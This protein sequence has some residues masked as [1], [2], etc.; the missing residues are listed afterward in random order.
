MYN[1][2]SHGTAD[3]IRGEGRNRVVSPTNMHAMT[4]QEHRAFGRLSELLAIFSKLNCRATIIAVMN[5]RDCVYDNEASLSRNT[6][7]GTPLLSRFDTIFKLVDSSDA[8]RD[9]NVTKYLLNRAILQASSICY[10]DFFRKHFVPQ[11]L[12]L[13]S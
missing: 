1:S 3:A 9:N 8:E 4:G 7:L 12:C 10:G 13:S 6:G 2:R 5:P 11:F